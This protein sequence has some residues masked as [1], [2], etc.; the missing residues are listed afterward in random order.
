MEYEEAPRV[1]ENCLP[2]LFDCLYMILGLE[3]QRDAM[4]PISGYRSPDILQKLKWNPGKFSWHGPFSRCLVH[5]IINSLRGVQVV[6][7]MLLM[8]MLVGDEENKRAAVLSFALF[9]THHFSSVSI[10][11]KKLHLKTDQ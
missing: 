6:I 1:K 3:V 9:L 10:L 5:R 7:M 2:D 11:R 4:G 8:L